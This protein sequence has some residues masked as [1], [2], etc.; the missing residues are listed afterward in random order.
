[1]GPVDTALGVRQSNSCS[2][3]VVESALLDRPFDTISAC[4]SEHLASGAIAPMLSMSSAAGV[5]PPGTY[6]M[7]CCARHVGILRQGLYRRCRRCTSRAG[8]VECV[9][10]TVDQPAGAS[11]L[12]GLCFG[13]GS[14]VGGR[15]CDW[16]RTW[17]RRRL[18]GWRALSRRRTGGWLGAARLTWQLFATAPSLKT[19]ASA[20]P[21]VASRRGELGGC[22]VMSAVA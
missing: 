12:L 16:G 9:L 17:G 8:A 21:F 2:S 13:L 15:L 4:R 14:R 22:S 6:E 5:A 7:A 1:M 10:P 19:A 3:A 20:K 11:G 18:L